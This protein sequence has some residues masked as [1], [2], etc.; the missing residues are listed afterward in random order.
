[1]P[2][3]VTFFKST[4]TSQHYILYKGTNCRTY[5]KC[6]WAACEGEGRLGFGMGIGVK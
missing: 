6:T 4:H 3:I 1:M 2:F 5:D